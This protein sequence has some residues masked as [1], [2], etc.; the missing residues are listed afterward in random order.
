MKQLEKREV[1]AFKPFICELCQN[2]FY[3]SKANTKYCGSSCSSIAY[4]ARIKERNSILSSN[5][6]NTKVE[7]LEPEIK[8]DNIY[9][10]TLN[11]DVS[12]NIVSIEVAEKEKQELK[13]D[14]SWIDIIYGR[15]K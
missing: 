13:T 7:I 3:T 4:R 5:V 15:K 14:R 10:N 11:T 1:K 9:N 12:E 2:L 8:S 6:D